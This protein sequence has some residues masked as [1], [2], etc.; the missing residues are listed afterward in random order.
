MIIILTCSD[1]VCGHGRNL[2][3]IV[4]SLLCRFGD[5]DVDAFP[6]Q[7][8]KGY[9]PAGG[10]VGDPGGLCHK[11]EAADCADEHEQRHGKQYVSA[12]SLL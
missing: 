9:R 3:F 11:P 7:E 4:F 12:P 6:Q 8:R 10:A 5:K 2:S 1:D